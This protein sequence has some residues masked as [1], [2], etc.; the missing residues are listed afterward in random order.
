MIFRSLEFSGPSRLIHQYVWTQRFLSKTTIGFELG[1]IIGVAYVQLIPGSS[2]ADVEAASSPFV[3]R[4]GDGIQVTFDAAILFAVNSSD[5]TSEAKASLADL[6]FSL[7][8]YPNTHVLVFGHTDNTGAAAYNQ[9][10]SEKR[11]SSAAIILADNGVDPNRLEITGY[12]ISKPIAS[13]DTVEGRRENH[14]LE[15]AIYASDE[16]VRELESGN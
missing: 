2:A 9:T 14:R 16:Y 13:S 5:L 4:V 6:A 15:I 7:Q 1:E 11:A 12:G 3:E 8:Q 10:L